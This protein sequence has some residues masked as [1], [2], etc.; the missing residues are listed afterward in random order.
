VTQTRK[1]VSVKILDKDYQVAC[2][3]DEEAL[4]SIS[5]RHLD[6]S[7]RSI[8][9]SGKVVGSDRIA[10]MAALNVTNELLHGPETPTAANPAQDTQIQKMSQKIDDALNRFSQLEC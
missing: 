8:R 5:A 7:M 6:N 10:V 9:S 4:L 3:P 2:G 1:T